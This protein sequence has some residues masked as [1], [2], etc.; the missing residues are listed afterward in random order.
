MTMLIIMVSW[1]AALFA[2]FGLYAPTNA[3]VVSSLC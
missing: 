2:S 1:L 3:T